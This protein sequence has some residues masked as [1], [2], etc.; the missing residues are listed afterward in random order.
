[1]ELQSTTKMYQQKPDEE[2][3][4]NVGA[5]SWNIGFNIMTRTLRNRVNMLPGQF[6][7]AWRK[8]Q[9]VINEVEM[10]ELLWEMGE[11]NQKAQKRRRLKRNS[12]RPYP[13]ET[14]RSRLILEAKQDRAQLVFGWKKQHVKPE[15]SPNDFILQEGSEECSKKRLIDI[16]E[17]LNSGCLCTFQIGL[18]DSSENNRIPKQQR[19]DGSI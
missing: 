11:R 18:L 6:L 8:L 7:R 15:N 14:A 4:I 19:P 16:T 2:E 1:M 10:S 3:V 9:S 17:R 13:S 5:F 12:L